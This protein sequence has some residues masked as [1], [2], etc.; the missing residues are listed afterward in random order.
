ME[1]DDPAVVVVAVVSS[2]HF[3]KGCCYAEVL[4]QWVEV[5]EATVRLQL[6]RN[7]LLPGKVRW[8]PSRKVVAAVAAADEVGIL[9]QVG[10]QDSQIS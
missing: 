7:H 3:Q 4:G 10:R 1:T 6:Q 8:I 9:G 2:N 5:V